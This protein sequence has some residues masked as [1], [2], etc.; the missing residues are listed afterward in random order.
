MSISHEGIGELV[1][2]YKHHPAPEA[3][4]V[5]FSALELKLPGQ[6]YNLVLPPFLDLYNIQVFLLL[7]FFFNIP[8]LAQSDKRISK[9]MIRAMDSPRA[10]FHPQTSNI[11][12]RRPIPVIKSIPPPKQ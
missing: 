11:I 2:G 8:V 5:N 4:D 10:S 1:Q 12:I 7:Y 6:V 9:E 3:F